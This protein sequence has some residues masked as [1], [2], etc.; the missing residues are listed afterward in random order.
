[1]PLEELWLQENIHKKSKN[2]VIYERCHDTLAAEWLPHGIHVSSPHHRSK[3]GKLRRIR[4]RHM[5]C[6]R[7]RGP[8]RWANRLKMFYTH[9][10]HK[11]AHM[12]ASWRK[13]WTSRAHGGSAEPW[14]RP[15]QPWVGWSWPSMWWLLI[16]PRLHCWGASQLLSEPPDL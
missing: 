14:V 8:T 6:T 7:I 16:G 12:S 5:D 9:R 1:L 2:G 15:N 4:R 3:G 13:K 11:K 10:I